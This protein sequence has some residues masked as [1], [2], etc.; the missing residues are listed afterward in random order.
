MEQLFARLKTIEAK[1]RTQQQSL[2][3]ISRSTANLASSSDTNFAQTSSVLT[4]LLCEN[5][6]K[7]ETVQF[8]SAREKQL[9]QI[10]SN[11]VVTRQFLEDVR[12]LI[13]EK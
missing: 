12:A 7:N 13:L 4:Q 3:F 1:L 9:D 6:S 10:Q 5:N 8:D 2:D 11:L